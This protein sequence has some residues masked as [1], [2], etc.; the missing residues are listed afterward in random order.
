MKSL[1]ELVPLKA[2]ARIFYYLC[3]AWGTM[4]QYSGKPP[5]VS[6]DPPEL[7]ISKIWALEDT[8]PF[9]R[10]ACEHDFKYSTLKP[11]QNTKDIDEEFFSCCL[12]ECENETK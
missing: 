2:Q 12:G 8:H 6:S 10:C 1:L 3:R 9:Y 11:W 5:P 7:G 4:R